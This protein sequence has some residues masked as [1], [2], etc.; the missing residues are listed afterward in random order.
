MLEQPLFFTG[1]SHLKIVFSKNMNFVS[2][3]Y[4]S[5]ETSKSSEELLSKI[6]VTTF[7]LIYLHSYKMTCETF[8]ESR[9]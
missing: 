3:T 9:V 7:F 6:C 1:C 5:S 4:S 2:L 8:F